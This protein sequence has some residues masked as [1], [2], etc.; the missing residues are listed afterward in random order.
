MGLFLSILLPVL[1]IFC[2]NEFFNIGSWWHQSGVFNIADVGNGLIWLGVFLVLIL[3]GKRKI[4]WNPISGLII[5][6]ILFVCIH[7][8]LASLYYGQSL[9]DGLIGVRHQ[10]YYL[11]FFMFLVLFDDTKKIVQLLDILVVVSFVLVILAVIN[12]FGPTIFHHKWAEG[13]GIRSGITRAF[14]PGMS[15]ISFSLLWAFAKWINSENTKKLSRESTIF[16]FAAHFFRQT[17][18]RLIGVIM[19]MTSLLVIKRKWVPLLFLLILS[20]ISFGIIEATMEDNVMVNLFSSVYE[21]VV[22]QTGT[23]KPRLEQLELDLWEF[24]RHPWLGSGASAIRSV[25]EQGGTRLQVKMAA[26]SYK[27]DLGYTH[28]LKSYG[29]AGIVWLLLFFWFQ[30]SMGLRAQKR[31]RGDDKTLAM[32]ALSYLGFVI[33]SFVT[34]NHLM[35]PDGIIMVCLSAAVIVRLYKN[36]Q[37]ETGDMVLK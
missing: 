1:A 25:T 26:L 18:M 9:I 37:G 14:I 29:M 3:P 8:S 28:W 27:F 32:F 24:K 2:A 36:S 4:L 16:L 23:W 30:F 11:S 33:V 5:L 35:H 13:H 21:D 17:R 34:L 19:I 31:C 15:V 10:F 12:H 22:E 20:G 6:Y 7:I